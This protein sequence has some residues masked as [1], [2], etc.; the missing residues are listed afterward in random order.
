MR[1]KKILKSETTIRLGVGVFIQDKEG[2]VLLE[3]RK[4]C[5]LWCLPG[6]TVEAGE[7]ISEAALREVKE[8]TGFLIEVA[9][10]IGVYSNPQH[11][12]IDYPDSGPLHLIDLVLRGAIRG[13]TLQCSS[14]SF[15]VRFFAQDQL[16]P[17]LPRSVAGIEDGFKEKRGMVH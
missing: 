12:L 4:D 13:G 15:E 11:R 10:I 16:P 17:I 3:K 1:F 7:T 8:E 6:G 14:E 2:R 5:G 9:G